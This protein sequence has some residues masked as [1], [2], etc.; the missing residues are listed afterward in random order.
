MIQTIEHNGVRYAEILR[1]DAR[2]EQTVFFSPA[3][4]SFQ[5]GLLAHRAGFV[6]P[7]HYHNP[8][9]GK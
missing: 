4:S 5:F 7:P 9:G 8:S 2:V 6:E 3:E 1:A